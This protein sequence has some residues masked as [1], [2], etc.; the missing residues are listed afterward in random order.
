MLPPHYFLI[1]NSLDASGAERLCSP[2]SRYNGCHHK[3]SK[4]RLNCTED[5]RSQG[6][7]DS[8]LVICMQGRGQVSNPVGVCSL[9]CFVLDGVRCSVELRGILCRRVHVIGADV[10]WTLCGA[11]LPCF[12]LPV[13]FKTSFALRE[14]RTEGR[15]A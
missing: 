7:Y 6:Q 3:V 1:L 4:G 11:Y 12:C 13:C 14:V 5:G 10:C 15:V 9:R 2:V 8:A